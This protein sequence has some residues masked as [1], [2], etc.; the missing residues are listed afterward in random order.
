MSLDAHQ[1]RGLKFVLHG[2]SA[3]VFVEC[4]GSSADGVLSVLKVVLF[5]VFDQTGAH[6]LVV[7]SR[8]EGRGQLRACLL[9]QVSTHGPAGGQDHQEVAEQQGVALLRVLEQS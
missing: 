5:H 2:L 8:A 9:V 6:V 4:T 3:V 1:D 7:G